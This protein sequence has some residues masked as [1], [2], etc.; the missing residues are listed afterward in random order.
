MHLES[1]RGNYATTSIVS[2]VRI[3]LWGSGADQVGNVNQRWCTMREEFASLS[4]LALTVT[5]LV[6]LCSGL[7]AITFG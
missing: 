3:G 7:L 1:T 5:S 4:F 2:L 6:V